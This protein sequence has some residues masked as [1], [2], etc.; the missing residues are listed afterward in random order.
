ML[1]FREMV[2]HAVREHGDFPVY[3]HP[4]AVELDGKFPFQV[5]QLMPADRDG[6]AIIITRADPANPLGGDELTGVDPAADIVLLV[7]GCQITKL[8]VGPLLEAL[9]R[10]E[11]LIAAVRS[12]KNMTVL[13]LGAQ[14]SVTSRGYLLDDELDAPGSGLRM[15]NE[16]QLERLQ[17][18]ATLA[19]A[20]KDLAERT[21]AVRQL[22]AEVKQLRA[23]KR[24]TEEAP[25]RSKLAQAADPLL[26]VGSARR[27]LAAGVARTVRRRKQ[28]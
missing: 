8:P 24:A 25:A 6:R 2:D 17:L 3:I 7:L 4:S 26:P 11:L 28:P 13:R 15:A 21:T 5:T 10:A 22:R 18:A 9:S 1:A 12:D 19:Q 23:A 14:D 20:R 16:W 27:Q